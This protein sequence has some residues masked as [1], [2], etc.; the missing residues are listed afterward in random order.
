M[1]TNLV[2]DIDIQK[3]SIVSKILLKNDGGTVTHFAFDANQSLS[4]HSAPF[5]ALFQCIDGKFS[6]TID[7]EVHSLTN[8]ELILLPANIPHAVFAEEASKS[9]LIM[10]KVNK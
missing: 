9:I 3:G 1:R 4:K 10:I 5:D 2:S 6:V 8:N 7:N